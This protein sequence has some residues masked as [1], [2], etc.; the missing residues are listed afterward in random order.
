[1]E[2]RKQSRTT[3]TQKELKQLQK[4]VQQKKENKKTIAISFDWTYLARLMV[5][6]AKK[7]EESEEYI[8]LV[9]NKGVIDSTEDKIYMV[10]LFKRDWLVWPVRDKTMNNFLKT[11]RKQKNIQVIDVTELEQMENV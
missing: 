5:S 10:W 6:E 7:N 1:M 4:E 2:T 9:E 3:E 11:I 8:V